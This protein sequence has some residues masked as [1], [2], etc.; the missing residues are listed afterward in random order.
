M[1]LVVVRFVLVLKR[2]DNPRFSFK[3]VQLLNTQDALQIAHM[4]T[5]VFWYLIHRLSEKQN[6][7]G[8]RTCSRVTW[9]ICM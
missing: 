2:L 9:G 4:Y 7:L 6:R 5:A 8:S 3:F 1:V